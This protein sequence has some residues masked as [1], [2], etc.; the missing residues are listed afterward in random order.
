MNSTVRPSSP[1]LALTSSTHMRSASSAA[2]PPAPSE[3]VCG[4]LIPILTGGC[5][6][7]AAP[8]IASNATA[9]IPASFAMILI[10][11]SWLKPNVNGGARLP[12]CQP[13]TRCSRLL[14]IHPELLRHRGPPDV[15]RVL[16]RIVGRLP[17]HVARDVVDV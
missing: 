10:V 11:P 3:P 15:Q 13:E 16:R 14:E 12:A 5:C 1:P 9:S 6:A 2:C 4:M 7:V 8:E 17:V